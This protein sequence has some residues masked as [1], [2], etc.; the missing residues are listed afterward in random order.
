MI[1]TSPVPK[2]NNFQHS[3]FVAKYND[4]F[5]NIF[6]L[7]N[8][9]S[10]PFIFSA[11]IHFLI[12]HNTSHLVIP[13][14]KKQLC[15]DLKFFIFGMEVVVNKQLTV[16]TNPNV[17]IILMVVSKSRKEDIKCQF[18]PNINNACMVSHMVFIETG[19]N[20]N[21]SIGIPIFALR[22]DRLKN[23][24]LARPGAFLIILVLHACNYLFTLSSST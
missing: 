15:L 13:F 19:I 4:F 14:F 23:H 24:Q 20:Q 22:S 7:T 2:Y 21:I 12:N 9:N 16:R 3:K 18:R 1:C 11:Y 17:R 6:F 10:Q 8:H 5:I